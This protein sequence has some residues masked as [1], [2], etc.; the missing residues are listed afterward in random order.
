[1]FGWDVGWLVGCFLAMNVAG[2]ERK[3]APAEF[4]MTKVG[5]IRAAA[6]P[7]PAI[8]EIRRKNPTRH[9]T[10]DDSLSL[11]CDTPRAS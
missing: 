6:R 5:W 3:P 4:V 1:V 7:P 8:P 9:A 10:R 11:N 2:N